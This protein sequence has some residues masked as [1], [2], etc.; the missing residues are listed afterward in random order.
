MDPRLAEIVEELLKIVRLS[1]QDLSWQPFYADDEE[2]QRDLRDHAERLRRGDGSRLPELKFSL[3][4]TG[5]L[6]EIAIS[7]GWS[8]RY[9]RLADEFDGLYAG[10]W[11][12]PRKPGP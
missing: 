8:E 11:S 12:S 1:P 9:L 5:D 2:L 3:L 6:N 10:P 4:P 7:S